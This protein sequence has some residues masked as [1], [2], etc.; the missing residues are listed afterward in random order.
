MPIIRESQGWRW[1]T[2]SGTEV[3]VDDTKLTVLEIAQGISYR[4]IEEVSLAAPGEMIWE[5]LEDGTVSRRRV[6][7]FR[8]TI[9]EVARQEA[10]RQAAVA[11]EINRQAAVRPVIFYRSEPVPEVREVAPAPYPDEELIVAEFRRALRRVLRSSQRCT[12]DLKP[13]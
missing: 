4:A 1:F 10:A 5:R 13:L 11:A 6:V 2:H 12:K 9:A 8:E 7:S 3:H